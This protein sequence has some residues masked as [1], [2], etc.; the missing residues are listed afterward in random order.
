VT[1]GPVEPETYHYHFTVDG[2]RTHDAGNPFLKIGSTPSTIMNVLEVRGAEPMFFDGRAVPHGEVRTNWY[3]SRAVGALRRVSVYLPPGYDRD[4]Q[5]R[6]PVL[7]LLHGANLDETAWV[8][9][10]RANLIMDSLLADGKAR[11]FIIVMPLG[12]AVPP[13]D[14]SMQSQNTGQFSRDLREDLIPFIE[15]EYR[16]LTD[17]IHRGL[18]GL[19]MGAGQALTVGL[20]HP[21]LFS[22]VGSFSTGSFTGADLPS[23]YARLIADPAATNRQLSL[24]WVGCGTEDPRIEPTRAF[25]KFLTQHGIKHG[26][27]ETSGDHTFIVWRKFLR[28]TAPLMF[29]ATGH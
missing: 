2:V 27:G 14:P 13:N 17:R 10:G 29:R 23:A 1:V 20:G 5:A 11:P 25:A 15:R 16:T 19:S 9:H 12:Y 8:R 24:F 3:H 4:P 21:E 18:F 26:Y 6:Y 28:D 7:Y 22:H